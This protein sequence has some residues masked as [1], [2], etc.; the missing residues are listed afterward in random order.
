MSGSDLAFQNSFKTKNQLRAFIFELAT[1]VPIALFTLHCRKVVVV[2][3]WYFLEL[4]MPTKMF[5]AALTDS[6]GVVPIQKARNL[7]RI[8]TIACIA[9]I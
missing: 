7:P 1:G 6:D 5:A 3:Y 2:S 9:P 8:L 4:T